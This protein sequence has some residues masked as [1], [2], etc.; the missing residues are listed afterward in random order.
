MDWIVMKMS[1]RIENCVCLEEMHTVA[2][3]AINNVGHR[4]YHFRPGPTSGPTIQPGSHKSK[5]SSEIFN[6]CNHMNMTPAC[7]I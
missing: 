4:P 1:G 6:M 3:L 5:I 7:Y 2:A